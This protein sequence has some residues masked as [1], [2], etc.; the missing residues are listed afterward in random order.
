MLLLL[1]ASPYFSNSF[2]IRRPLLS[3]ISHQ[4]H[5]WDVSINIYRWVLFLPIHSFA[6][7]FFHH[8]YSLLSSCLTLSNFCIHSNQFLKRYVLHERIRHRGLRKRVGV[9]APTG[10]AFS[11]HFLC[12]H[13]VSTFF[14]P[15][16]QSFLLHS[17]MVPLREKWM[18]GG[19]W[20]LYSLE[21]IDQHIQPFF[22]FS[23]KR[24]IASYNGNALSTSVVRPPC[25]KIPQYFFL[26]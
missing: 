15:T 2:V 6:A 7:H 3:L 1:G 25:S 16:C 20:P 9:G 19:G 17:L 5:S 8:Q 13:C 14:S 24:K 12:L 10:L 23:W 18:K 21:V 11:V 4:R 22:F 26:G